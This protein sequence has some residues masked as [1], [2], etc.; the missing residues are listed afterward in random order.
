MYMALVMVKFINDATRGMLSQ[1]YESSRT[2]CL[3]CTV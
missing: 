1:T 3:L 2:D